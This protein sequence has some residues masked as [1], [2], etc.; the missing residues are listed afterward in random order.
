M[1]ETCAECGLRIEGTS[2]ELPD[3]RK[4]CSACLFEKGSV[5]Q[6]IA[7]PFCGGIDAHLPGCRGGYGL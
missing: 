3:G 7:C 2:F 4:V 1:N 6:T 5:K